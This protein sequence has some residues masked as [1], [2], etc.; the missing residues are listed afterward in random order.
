M[1]QTDSG[2]VVCGAESHDALVPVLSDKVFEPV[3]LDLLSPNWGTW[4]GLLKLNQKN[5]HLIAAFSSADRYKYL[6]YTYKGPVD[7]QGA[8]LT[9]VLSFDEAA[10][11]NKLV[12]FFNTLGDS[13]SLVQ[14]DVDDGTI[15]SDITYSCSDFTQAATNGQSF[16]LG[17][18]FSA[19]AGAVTVKSARLQFAA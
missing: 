2:F 5:N 3:V 14:G 9:V 16:Q 1:L 17:L 7:L 12:G 18:V 8:T 6:Y 10:A 13:W 15:G 11:A 19:T 4:D